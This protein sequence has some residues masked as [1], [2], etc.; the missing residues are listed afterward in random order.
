MGVTMIN[1]YMEKKK[2]LVLDSALTEHTVHDSMHEVRGVDFF[3]RVGGMLSRA[4]T[5]RT[6]FTGQ[7]GH[8]SAS[9]VTNNSNI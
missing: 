9:L 5:D 4:Q 3:R 6:S 2:G 8:R 7:G 1:K